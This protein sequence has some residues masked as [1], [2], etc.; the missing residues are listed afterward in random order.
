MRALIKTV[1]M[2]VSGNV[3]LWTKAFGQAWNRI[4]L[5]EKCIWIFFIGNTI[6]VIT[7]LE[8]LLMKK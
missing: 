4:S 6:A 5:T 7:L 8:M 1:K 3:Y 2:A